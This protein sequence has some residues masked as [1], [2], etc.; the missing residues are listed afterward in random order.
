MQNS[1]LENQDLCFTANNN[2]SQF[3]N[4]TKIEGNVDCFNDVLI[5]KSTNLNANY[6]LI[7]FGGDIQVK[8]HNLNQ[9]RIHIFHFFLVKS[10]ILLINTG[11]S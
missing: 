10:Y 2:N 9:T 7:Y 6:N 11:L 3:K 4:F 5:F 1:F 8:I